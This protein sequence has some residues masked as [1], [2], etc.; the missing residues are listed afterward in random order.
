MKQIQ[1]KGKHYILNFTGVF[2]PPHADSGFILLLT[3]GFLLCFSRISRRVKF[4]QDKLKQRKFTLK[5]HKGPNKITNFLFISIILFH[6][7]VRQKKK[8]IFFFLFDM[9]QKPRNQGTTKELDKRH[10]R[11][12]NL[13]IRWVLPS[14]FVQT[15]QPRLKISGQFGRSG[16]A[17]YEN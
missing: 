2:D 7:H 6:V 13:K 3:L 1:R 17:G 12:N 5:W 9:G 10:K 14:A 11:S 8:K 16:M 4:W 15:A